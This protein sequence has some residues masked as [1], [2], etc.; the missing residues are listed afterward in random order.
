MREQVDAFGRSKGPA[1]SWFPVNVFPNALI[2]ARLTHL[3][4]RLCTPRL[5]F[6]G[7]T[8]I[9]IS[10]WLSLRLYAIVCFVSMENI[11]DIVPTDEPHLDST[12]QIA[13]NALQASG[14]RIAAAARIYDRHESPVGRIL[15][16]HATDKPR[17]VRVLA[18]AKIE[19]R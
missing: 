5:M 10:Y 17:A 6:T 9:F 12:L 15:L 13:I 11:I 3:R 7:N 2:S 18:A 4:S 1:P 8:A 16:Q 19:V 14:V